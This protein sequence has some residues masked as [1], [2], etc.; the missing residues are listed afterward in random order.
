MG[1]GEVPDLSAG[2]GAASGAGSDAGAGG[3]AGGEQIV[4]WCAAYAIINCACQRCHQNPPIHNAPLPLVTYADTQGPYQGSSVQKT[5]WQEMQIVVA[6][7]YMPFTG[8]PILEPPVEPLT[9]AQQSTLLMWLGQG[10]RDEGGQDC[11]QA[12]DW[13]TPAP[14]GA[15]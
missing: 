2:A 12:C 14:M 13:S 10:A 1:G 4:Q 8:P 5:V 3:A 11:P 6:N 9:D 7:H 15:R